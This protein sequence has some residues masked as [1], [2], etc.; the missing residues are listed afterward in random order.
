MIR[1]KWRDKYGSGI[2]LISCSNTWNIGKSKQTIRWDAEHTTCRRAHN[3]ISTKCNE[4]ICE[5]NEASSEP[6]R[7][8]INRFKWDTAIHIV[9]YT[10]ICKYVCMHTH[11]DPQDKGI[12]TEYLS[13]KDEWHPKLE[14]ILEN[15]YVSSKVM[16]NHLVNQYEENW[17][18]ELQNLHWK[19]SIFGRIIIC[20]VYL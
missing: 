13:H 18:Q 12:W 8:P 15:F 17:S 5:Q 19:K 10:T 4:S 3:W 7:N 14:W 20:G 6:I 1:N 2:I 16:K 9:R 11:I